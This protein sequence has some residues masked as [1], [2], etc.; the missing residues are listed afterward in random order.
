MNLKTITF[1]LLI[2]TVAFGV[3]A[4]ADENETA[5]F[6]SEIIKDA[7][8]DSERSA[9]LMEAVS[10]AEDNAKLKIALLEKSVE[11]GMKGLKTSDDCRKFQD[12]LNNLVR[13]DSSRRAHW[14][15]QRAAVYRRWCTLTRS[16]TDKRKLAE[17]AVASF[18]EA[19]VVTANQGQW[20]KALGYFNNA[21]T[22]IAAYRLS[23]PTRLSGFIRAATYLYKAQRKIDDQIAAV[24]KS[25]RDL[26]ARS[27]LITTLVTVMDDPAAAAKHLN[28]D[29][30]ERFRIFVP[31]AAKDISKQDVEA[32]RNLGD[33]Y[34][35]E[36]SKSAVP[37]VKSRMLARARA[38]YE[39]VLTLHTA[40]DVTAATLKMSLA[41]I[42]S[43]QAKLGNVDPLVCSYC[44]GSGKTACAS[45]QSGGQATGLARCSYCKGS[46]RSKCRTCGGTWRVKCSKCSGRGK[47]VSGQ[48]RRGGFVYKTYSKCY[49]CS[50][51]GVTYRSRYGSTRS[52]TCPTCSKQKIELRGASACTRCSGKG[53]TGSCRR[54]KG[55]KVVRCTRCAAGKSGS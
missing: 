39:R 2:L 33:W 14:L 16:S 9:L 4:A 32:C 15:S 20:K 46:G 45:C 8:T 49:T 29:V 3:S 50:G 17:A 44:S 25:P 5:K 18:T 7:R 1:G 38:Y 31:M 55:D 30:D 37:V 13:D 21:K 48:V 34:F 47:V 52:G 6:I 26:D 36:L 22:T 40:G 12:V 10:L 24:K 28:E 43:D 54:C 19:G 11:F 41:R 53:G 27:R 42:K 35:K 23:N 51:K